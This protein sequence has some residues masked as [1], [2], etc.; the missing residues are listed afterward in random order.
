MSLLVAIAI[1]VLFGVI[2]KFLRIVP[3]TYEVM[4]ISRRVLAIMGDATLDD[5]AKEAGLQASARRLFVLLLLLSAG[6]ALA[7]L[8]P[9]G[10]AWLLQAAG[11]LTLDSVFEI[12]LRWDFMGGITIV[13]LVL[14]LVFRTFA[15]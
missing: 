6:S 3:R 15:R 13:A 14:Y 4:T 10:M 7:I 12:L 9:L 5:D 11:V 2:I 1:V 8:V